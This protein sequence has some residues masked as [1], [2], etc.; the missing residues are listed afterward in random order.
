MTEMTSTGGVL[1]MAIAI[2]SLLEIKPI[3]T[4]NLLPALFIAPLL[5]AVLTA[6]GIN[7]SALP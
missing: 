6:F 5:I 3:R 7:W 1:L 4:G 2:S